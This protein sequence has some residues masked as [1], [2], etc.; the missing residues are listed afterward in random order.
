M[1][2]LDGCI[3]EGKVNLEVIVLNVVEILLKV[4]YI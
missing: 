3:K 4:E 2:I 1:N